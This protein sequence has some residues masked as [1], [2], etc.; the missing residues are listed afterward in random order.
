MKTDNR[1]QILTAILGLGL[2][3][4]CAMGQCSDSFEGPLNTGFW[5]TSLQ[6]GY[7]VCPSST[8]AHSGAYSLELA[9]TETGLNKNVYVYHQFPGQTYGQ[10]SIWLYDTGAS[11]GSANYMG[12]EVD[13]AGLRLASVGAWD[14]N[15]GDGSTYNYVL[16]DSSYNSPITRTAAWH[17]FE[18]AALPNA[19]TLSIDGTNI[20]TGPGGQTFDKFLMYLA[21][22]SWRPA[23]TAQFD[24][25]QFTPDPGLDVHMY[26][27]L[28]L[29][30]T[31]GR[32]YQIQY[33]TNLNG[34]NWQP[35]ADIPL[36]TSPCLYFD[37][38]SVSAPKRFY[39][40][41]LMP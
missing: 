33:S 8:R 17:K 10:V 29:S 34:T 35:L 18:I 19:F 32:T 15:F 13:S 3:A 12:I 16:G 27:G 26:A 2:V 24:D 28:T 9:S 25:F 37:T 41:V 31:V 14:Y 30:G 39:R 23:W 20:Y 22:P 36:S 7:V 40:A 21:G 1:N 38:N 6:S 5:S 4:V 11:A